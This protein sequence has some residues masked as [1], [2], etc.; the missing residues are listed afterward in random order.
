MSYDTTIV[1]L[2]HPASQ[3]ASKS[4]LPRAIAERE[5]HLERLMPGIHKPTLLL[6][7][8][9]CAVF[10]SVSFYPLHPTDLW[11]HLALGRWAGEQAT[12]TTNATLP[13]PA[14]DGVQ[15][16]NTAWL[17]QRV[18]Y[19]WFQSTGS[20]GLQLAHALLATLSAALM[21]LAVRSRKVSLLLAIAA[22][23]TTYV[24][25]LPVIGVLRPQM[26]GLVALPLV[27]YGIARMDIGKRHPLVWL[28][29]VMLLWA[30]LHGS[31]IVG[32]AAIGC[33][34]VARSWE[35][36]RK[37]FVVTAFI[38]FCTST[39]WR[40]PMNRATTNQKVIAWLAVALSIAACCIHPAGPKLLWQAISFGSSSNLAGISEWQ[41]LTIKSLSGGLFFA[42]LAVTAVLLRFSKRN[43]RAY[44]V[45]LLVGLALGTLLA[46]RMLV[47]WAIVWPWVVAPHVEAII[48]QRRSA[49]TDSA[50]AQAS[51]ATPV[52]TLMATVCLLLTLIWS[53]PSYAMITSQQR[54]ETQVLAADTPVYL[55]EEAERRNLAG[56]AFVPMEWADYLAFQSNGQ[57]QP[58]VHSH[59]HLIT[60]ELMSDYQRLMAGHS[61]WLS[62]LDQHNARY[63]VVRN[64]YQFRIAQQVRTHPR[65]RL[66]Y[67]DQQGAIFEILPAASVGDVQ[68]AEHTKAKAPQAVQQ[69]ERNTQQQATTTE[70]NP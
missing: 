45:L 37:P 61:D 51:I 52:Y 53:P 69:I 6:V 27:L 67:R 54:A 60:P 23:A 42:S 26:F 39:Y 8:L 31:F 16:I 41:P 62:I 48:A 24:L 10:L 9:L 21:V 40:N 43:I 35:D 58:L 13:L 55:A 1:E 7:M 63:L 46:I 20:Q 33:Y 34:A 4:V 30:N 15:A 14:A 17:S 49:N 3:S 5:I 11:G 12:E 18:L 28:P 56:R 66:L 36:R 65:T 59:V 57:L 29:L 38:Q 70:V 22:A 64:I 32:L 25:T 2:L 50:N 47:W 44:E 68:Q 19:H